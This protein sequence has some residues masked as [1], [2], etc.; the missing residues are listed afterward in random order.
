[1]RWL[2]LGVCLGHSMFTVVFC[3]SVFQGLFWQDFCYF[4]TYTA[5]QFWMAH[6]FITFFKSTG[7]QQMDI[8][9]YTFLLLQFQ[10]CFWLHCCL[11]K[12]STTLC[13]KEE[14]G[15]LF[16]TTY[17][18]KTYW[19]SNMFLYFWFK[20]FK[21]NVVGVF[22]NL[23]IFIL[24]LNGPSKDWKVFIF[25]KISIWQITPVV[26]DEVWLDFFV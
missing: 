2:L 21:N 12:L 14:E 20:V 25:F 26:G 22:N 7:F 6:H 19:F 13:I 9:G 10:F 3:C 18:K 1:M 5:Q 24:A 17:N 11:N 23:H 4:Q 15:L 8:S 16:E